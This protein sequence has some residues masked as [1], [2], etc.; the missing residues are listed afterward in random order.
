MDSNLPKFAFTKHHF[1]QGVG[2]L[3]ACA[4]VFSN[5]AQYMT[6]SNG[7]APYFQHVGV[8]LRRA[9]SEELHS[10]VRVLEEQE[11]KQLEFKLPS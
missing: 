9:I 3:I 11:A 1:L 6:T 4:P 5:D 8:Y 2:L 10:F 7:I